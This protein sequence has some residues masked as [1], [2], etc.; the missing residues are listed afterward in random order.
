MPVT[1]YVVAFTA[2]HGY[3]TRGVLAALDSEALSSRAMDNDNALARFKAGR[4]DDNV[5]AENITV[6]LSPMPAA[7][8]E[9][10]KA[11]V[12]NSSLAKSKEGE[13]IDGRRGAKLKR[14]SG[15]AARKASTTARSD[16]TGNVA[17]KSQGNASDCSGTRFTSRTFT[18]VEECH[19][20]SPKAESQDDHGGKVDNVPPNA[21]YDATPG[22]SPRTNI[23]S[24]GSAS[25]QAA[26]LATT[27]V[28]TDSDTTGAADS[29][30]R[31]PSA[32]G[33]PDC[34]KADDVLDACVESVTDTTKAL[35]VAAPKD[36]SGGLPLCKNVVLAEVTGDNTAGSTGGDSAHNTIEALI[37]SLNALSAERAKYLAEADKISRALD[38]AQEVVTSATSELDAIAVREQEMSDAKSR[39]NDLKEELHRL[40]QKVHDY[41][42]SAP[43]RTEKIYDLK[44]TRSDGESR[45]SD[46]KRQLEETQTSE[47]KRRA[48]ID[49]MHGILQGGPS[50]S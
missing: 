18:K 50:M 24:D 37:G 3:E 16:Q 48:I 1:N 27:K 2:L 35:E 8:D 15:R 30:D 42:A 46:L 14:P 45:R 26:V 19:K 40:E 23:S 21:H 28:S 44:R 13:S 33:S 32:A 47:N 29:A 9:N 36:Q 22:E 10:E 5:E 11:S 7:A 31:R 25:A 6:A 39:M 20:A 34:A 12:Y 41:D 4:L 49:R 38:E 17:N 43:T